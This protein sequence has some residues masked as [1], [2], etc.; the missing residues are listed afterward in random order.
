M[1]FPGLAVAVEGVLADGDGLTIQLV[2][3]AVEAACPACG[4]LSRRVHGWC[5]RRLRDVAVAG[6]RIVLELRS[7]RLVCRNGGC[8]QRTFREQIPDLT[9]RWARR[10]P[11]VTALIARFGIAV[12]GRAGARLLDAAGVSVSRDTVLRG[13][14]SQPLPFEQAQAAGEPVPPVLGVDDVAIRRGQTY[15]TIIIDG[16]GHRP[17]DLLPDRLADTLATW[18]RAHPGVQVVC[19]DGSSAYAQAIRDG[20]PRAV[21]VND[22][23][24]LWHGLGQAVE[25]VVVAHSGCWRPT[26]GRTL[27]PAPDNDVWTVRPV[28]EQTTARHR[29]VH[30][31]LAEGL[32][33]M[34]CRR[35]L[36]WSYNAVKRYAQAAT[37][38][39]LHR[40]PRY[41]ATLVD[42][43]RDHLR[44]RLIEQPSAPVTHLLDEIRALGYTGS[45]NLL[46]RYINQGR[47]DQEHPPV[48]PRTLTSWMM[49]DPTN[50]DPADARQLQDVLALCPHL[51]ETALL[52]TKLAHMIM[53]RVSSGLA[54]W[55]D[56]TA[57][58]AQPALTSFVHG[59]RLDQAAVVAA[60]TLDFSNGPTEGTN[61]KIKLL[62][63]QMYGRAAFPLLRQRILLN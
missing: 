56:A 55:M 45:A 23:W 5:R 50:L 7:R 35:R 48:K 10:T 29:M 52:V 61:T 15:A 20:A 51:S 28:D 53:N 3:T 1:L 14:M 4:A 60:L 9:R 12:A 58:L 57:A 36:G 17:L 6:R 32:G 27:K 18:L 62:K 21:Q 31:L 13:V 8:V 22:R 54:A 16:A 24:H 37:A 43:Y 33:L 49:T 30:D 19:R 39:E 38:Q 25:K 46:V 59:L 34:E 44:R 63:R 41:R 26:A 42:P 11:R 40:P 2:S 47:L